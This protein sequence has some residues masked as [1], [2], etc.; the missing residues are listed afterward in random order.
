MLHLH[1]VDGKFGA[2]AETHQAT[3]RR[4]N[5]RIDLQIGR[6]HEK[7]MGSYIEAWISVVVQRV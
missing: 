7:G 6:S 1:L 5:N 3:F 2:S 4:M